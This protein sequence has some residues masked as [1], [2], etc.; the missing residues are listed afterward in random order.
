MNKKILQGTISLILALAMLFVSPIESLAQAANRS[1]IL[2]NGTGVVLRLNETFKANN[3]ADTGVILATVTDDVY[4]AD[5]SRILIAAGTPA[6]IEFNAEKNGS[7]G[8]AGQICLTHATTKTI[9][10]K[11]VSLRLSSCKKGGSTL[12]GVI[13]LSVLFFPLGLISLC[14]K[15]SMP[16]LEQGTIFNSTVNQDI[17]VD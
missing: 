6:Q 1:N 11:R 14:M 9:D 3:K 2:E 7:C 15:G 10:N 8:K 17:V 12:G 4:S 5:G 13:A 16:K